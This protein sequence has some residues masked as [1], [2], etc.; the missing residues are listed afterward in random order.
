M[1]E[2]VKIIMIIE[3]IILDNFPHFR[4]N[5]LIHIFWIFICIIICNGNFIDKINLI[6]FLRSYYVISFLVRPKGAFFYNYLFSY[7]YYLC[8]LMIFYFY[9]LHLI[10]LYLQNFFLSLTVHIFWYYNFVFFLFCY[11]FYLILLLFLFVVILLY[12]FF[13]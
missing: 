2:I 11:L 9:F 1:R 7:I 5:S 12:Y 10:Y 8:F 3:L 6:I 13:G 4:I